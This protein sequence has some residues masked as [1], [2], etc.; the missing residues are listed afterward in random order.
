MGT[1][2][3][4]DD[5][6]RYLRS[7]QDKISIGQEGEALIDIDETEVESFIEDLETKLAEVVES[8]GISLS[9][10]A[11]KYIII[12]WVCHDIYRAL[13]PRAS[14]NEIPMAVQ[15]WKKDA[16]EFL[17]MKIEGS[18]ESAGEIC[19]WSAAL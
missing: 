17:E 18:E 13:Y 7:N 12:R 9:M 11:S 6:K 16:D 10:G 19:D 3:T 14:V 2:A 5:I 1:Y 15:G 8:K 4:L